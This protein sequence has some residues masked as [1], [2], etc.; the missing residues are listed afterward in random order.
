MYQLRFMRSE[1]IQNDQ[2]RLLQVCL[3][4]LEERDDLLFFDAAFVKAKK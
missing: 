2:Q 1:S 3:E 4:R